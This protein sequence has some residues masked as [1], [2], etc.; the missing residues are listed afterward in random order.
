MTKNTCIIPIR[1]KSKGIKNKNI[2]L[3]AGKPLVYH[4][5]KSAIDSNLFN[6]IIIATDSQKYISFIKKYI[7]NEKVVFFLR[8]K[9]S[10]GEKTQSEVVLQEV[11]L[12]TCNIGKNVIFVQATSPLLSSANLIQAL[13]KFKKHNYDSLFSSCKSHYFLWKKVK[14]KLTS[15][16]YNYKKRI[17]RQESKEEFIETGS[18]YIFKKNG[19]LKNK[20]RL[21]GKIGNFSIPELNSIDID[22]LYD[23]KLAK[24]L[25]KNKK[26]LSNNE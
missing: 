21:F 5:C 24:I 7:K 9:K 19:F 12:R 2:K 4:A 6:K 18:F 11:I 15:I 26:Y 22:N 8:S 25:I 3:I 14:Q 13:K 10:A 16:N 1:S 17:M 23:F 20:N